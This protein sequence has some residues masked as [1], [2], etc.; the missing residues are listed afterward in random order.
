[1]RAGERDAHRVKEIRPLH[2]RS[3]LYLVHPVLEDLRSDVPGMS[4]NTGSQF[5]QNG[6]GGVGRQYSYVLSLCPGSL[7][8][9]TEDCGSF[10]WKLVKAVNG[11]EKNREELIKPGQNSLGGILARRQTAGKIA[12]GQRRKPS[13]VCLLDGMAIE[14]VQLVQVEDAGLAVT[15]SS[16]KASISSFLE[17][18]SVLPSSAPQPSRAR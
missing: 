11:G 5:A 3:N 16:E 14:P 8:L 13:G 1:M 18:I 7:R 6:A 17:K 9:E 4:A 15:R 12:P 10:L 2:T